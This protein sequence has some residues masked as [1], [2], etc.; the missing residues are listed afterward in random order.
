MSNQLREVGSVDELITRTWASDHVC[1]LDQ[2]V[3]LG[4]D[5]ERHLSCVAWRLAWVPTVGS[6]IRLIGSSICPGSRFTLSDVLTT[7]VGHGVSWTTRSI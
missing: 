3:L 5:R 7:I 2:G 6:R 4:Y 1:D